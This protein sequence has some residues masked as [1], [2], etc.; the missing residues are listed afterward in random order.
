MVTT[1]QTGTDSKHST[2]QLAGAGLVAGP[3]RDAVIEFLSG[4]SSYHFSQHPDWACAHNPRDFIGIATLQDNVMRA[5]TLVRRRRLPVIRRSK[6]FGERGPVVTDLHLLPQHIRDITAALAEDGLFLALHPYVF[7][8]KGEN[9]DQELTRIGF[10]PWPGY[11]QH[12]D[13]TLTIDLDQPLTTIRANFRRSVK[14]QINKAE[15]LGITIRQARE[16]SDHETFVRAYRTAMRAKGFRSPNNLAMLLGSLATVP[17]GFTL[18]A[19]VK[20]EPVAGIALAGCGHYLVYQ[21]GFT[22]SEPKHRHLP[23]HHALHWH[24]IQAAKQAGY[25]CYD[26]GGYWADRGDNDP[27][28]HFKAGLTRNGPQSCGTPMALPFRR[29]RLLALL[30]QMPTLGT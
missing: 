24:A 18:L 11:R 20:D 10:T 4:Q 27:I 15:R 1:A 28:N 29:G 6:Y 12:Y 14:T 9:L 17:R 7:G 21:W 5:W 23:L 30:G 25:E 3:Q 2:F 13:T 19:C 8:E 26:L 22:S 16:P